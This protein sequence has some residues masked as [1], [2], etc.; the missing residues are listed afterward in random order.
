MFDIL[1]CNA[2]PSDYDFEKFYS[3]NSIKGSIAHADNLKSSV[4]FRNKKTLIM[5]KE[6]DFDIGSVKNIAEKRKA[7]F[8]I[9]LNTVIKSSG[10]QRSL[11][12][13]RLR[14]FLEQCNKHGAFY[15]FASFTEEKNQVRYPEELM[16]IAMLFGIN[17][18][19]ARFALNML[20][21]YLE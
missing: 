3:Y 4:K 12:I 1:K 14:T 10:I 6:Y 21:H 15:A 17:K 7:C 16:H 2:D 8:L 20:D 18:G 19:Q 11:R 5:L 9:D 13:S